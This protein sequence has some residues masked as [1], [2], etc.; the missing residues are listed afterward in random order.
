MAMITVCDV[1]G[2]RPAKALSMHVGRSFDGVETTNDYQSVDVCLDHAL[3]L[4]KSALSEIP[5]DQRV[6]LLARTK[7]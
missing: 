5:P 2:G 4:A 3:M 1:C 7:A 6:A